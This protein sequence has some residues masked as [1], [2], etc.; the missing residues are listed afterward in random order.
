LR[1]PADQLAI[2]GE[3]HIAFDHAGAHARGRFVGFFRV[4]G[5]LQRGAAMADGKIGLAK[6]P[7]ALLQRGL[8]RPVL[9]ALDEVERAGTDL[10]LDRSVLG[11]C[12]DGTR[13]IRKR[14]GNGKNCRV[15]DHLNSPPVGVPSIIV[16]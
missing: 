10:R 3:R 6:R 15:S 7:G 5:K 12:A 2:L 16:L 13:Q 14:H 11:V 9:H 8:Q 1:V 4:L